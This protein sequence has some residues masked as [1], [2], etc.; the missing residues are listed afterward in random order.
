MLPLR[1]TYTKNIFIRM[2]Q[3]HDPTHNLRMQRHSDRTSIPG[4][5]ARHD[6]QNV[7]VDLIPLR[8][9][10]C[11]FAQSSVPGDH[12]RRAPGLF[13][14]MIDL[15]E[16]ILG[17]GTLMLCSMLAVRDRGKGT[18]RHSRIDEKI[19]EDA[20]ERRLVVIE[21]FAFPLS[22]VEVLQIT[23]RDI[24]R[25]F[26]EV[27]DLHIP[28][29][30]VEDLGRISGDAA[31]LLR[32]GTPVLEFQTTA[33]VF[34]HGAKI[35]FRGAWLGDGVGIEPGTMRQIALVEAGG[36][37]FLHEFRFHGPRRQEVVRAEIDGPHGVT[38]GSVRI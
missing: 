2:R 25:H 28:D 3:I 13:C 36:A 9:E 17:E 30:A 10:N 24:R 22:A 18:R 16:F 38:E 19:T 21:T 32:R 31:V 23:E 6:R 15:P 26:I 35:G 33:A 14:C 4:R 5:L 20:V 7:A 29:E 37:V 1:G 27:D 11:L 34:V 8:I 12:D